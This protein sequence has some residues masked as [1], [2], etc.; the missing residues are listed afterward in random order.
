MS[1]EKWDDPKVSWKLNDQPGYVIGFVLK[2]SASVFLVY[3]SC[4]EQAAACI[5]CIFSCLNS[6]KA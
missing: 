4:V 3:L 2:S 1:C 6:S 5:K